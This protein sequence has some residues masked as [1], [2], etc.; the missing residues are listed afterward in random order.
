MSLV[1]ATP[2]VYSAS[3]ADEALDDAR[4]IRDVLAGALAMR[5]PDV[6]RLVVADAYATAQQL[7]DRLERAIAVEF[8]RKRQDTSRVAPAVSR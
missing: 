7:A 1:T 5:S 3:L 8:D 4:R 6:A 2:E